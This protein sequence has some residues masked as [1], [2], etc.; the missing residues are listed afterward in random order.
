MPGEQENE[1]ACDPTDPVT[2]TGSAGE[3]GSQQRQHYALAGVYR[4]FFRISMLGGNHDTFQY[5]V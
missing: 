2:D 1:D 3:V 4:V 5:T